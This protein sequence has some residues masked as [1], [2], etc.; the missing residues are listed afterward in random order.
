MSPR[1]SALMD[2][3]VIFRLSSVLPTHSRRWNYREERMNVLVAPATR[4]ARFLP[5]EAVLTDRP[6]GMCS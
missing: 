3:S 2:K 4:I 5:Y 6:L 1:A